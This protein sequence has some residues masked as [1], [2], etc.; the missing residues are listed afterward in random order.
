MGARTAT[1]GGG[2]VGWA[3]GVDGAEYGPHGR[4]V[5]R[6][7]AGLVVEGDVSTGH[8][9]AEFQAA[10]REALDGLRELP[11][12]LG[13]LRAAEV[14]AVGD[15]RGRGAGGGDVAVR[16]GEGELGTLVR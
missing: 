13:V 5:D 4:R 10:V 3:G 12:H 8:R 2:G 16:L 6:L 15:G 1:T 14:Q 11:H 9:D 7:V